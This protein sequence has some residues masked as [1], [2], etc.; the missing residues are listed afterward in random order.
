MFTRDPPHPEAEYWLVRLQAP[1]CSAEERMRFE[2]WRQAD[3]AHEQAY[4]SAQRYWDRAGELHGDAELA[5]IARDTLARRRRQRAFWSRWGERM[6]HLATAALMLIVVGGVGAFGYRAGWFAPAPMV[7]ATAVGERRTVPLEDGSTLLLNTNTTVAVRYRRFARQ[8]EL[9]RGEAQFDVAHDSQ[10]TFTVTAA[11]TS[12]TALGTR[13]QVRTDA[14]AT[15]VTL[16]QGR[17]RVEAPEGTS[18]TS[19]TVH[20]AELTP[21]QRLTVRTGGAPWQRDSI[22]PETAAGWTSGR[23]VFR[24]LP[25]RQAVE[26]I[27]RYTERKVRIDD[28]RLESI[29][30]NGVFDAGD[31][32]NVLDALQYAYPIAVD[33]RSTREIVLRRR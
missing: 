6:P 14:A 1:D 7:Y 21:G 8:V 13:F 11:E 29:R 20:H 23:L 26:E 3:P 16:L 27:N 10:R 24:A 4:R 2:A 33:D 18:G 31:A 25:L 9:T 19:G 5:A 28:P 22:D 32:R 15:A 12:V 30:V 17:V